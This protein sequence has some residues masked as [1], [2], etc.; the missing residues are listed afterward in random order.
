MKDQQT[1]NTE[2]QEV[3]NNNSLG[4]DTVQTE[5]SNVSQADSPEVAATEL[6]P[7]STEKFQA[8]LTAN[9]AKQSKLRLDYAKKLSELQEKY[10]DSMSN[11]LDQEHQA[12]R[13]IHEARE[14]YEKAKEDYEIK[15]HCIRRSRNEAGRDH[16]TGKAE[17]KNFWT[18]ENEK[19]QS[20]RHNIF[21][22]YRDSGGYFRKKPKGSCTQAG[23]ETRKEE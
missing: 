16:N 14:A 21:E 4:Q 1:N 9:T 10:D 8:L 6:Q 2:S 13:D 23:A 3:M 22:R 12:N 15:L 17:A 5:N 20:E 11:L 18:T 7:L 19:I